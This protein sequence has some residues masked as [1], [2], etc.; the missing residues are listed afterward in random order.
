MTVSC[1]RWKAESGERERESAVVLGRCGN[2]W[3]VV[4]CQEGA[5]LAGGY[6]YLKEEVKMM[7]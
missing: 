7:D 4:V 1:G 3:S 5:G 6:E 2:C